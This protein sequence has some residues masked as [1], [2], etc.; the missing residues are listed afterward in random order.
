M[1][2]DSAGVVEA[3]YDALDRGDFQEALDLADRERPEAEETDP[4]LL[5]LSGLA[6]L[7]LDR[8]GEAAER[9]ARVVELD[10]DD[11]EFEAGLALAL[12][13]CCRFVEAAAHARHAVEADGE[14]PDAR[15][16]LGIVLEREGR[17]GEADEQMLRATRLDPERFP[18]PP[19][20]SRPDFEAEVVRAGE[21]LPAR[22]RSLLAEVAVSVEDVPSEP[23]LREECPTLDPELLGLFVGVSLAERSSFGPVGTLPPRIL[24][25]KRN[26]ERYAADR[27][28]LRREI[29]VTLYHELGHYL[30]MDEGD[31]EEL[32]LA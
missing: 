27:E 17:F 28:D 2:D 7:E 3:I 26:L 11:A 16:V 21:L 6:L 15:S 31:L 30:G 14:S 1:E 20:M 5:F 25:F 8:P 4:V 24:L 29:A 23:I 12:F 19:R 10:P 9:L 22:F 13:R 32:D 18:A